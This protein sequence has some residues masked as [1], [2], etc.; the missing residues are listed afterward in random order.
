V[1]VLVVRGGRVLYNRTHENVEISQ[2]RTVTPVY[3][4]GP[5]HWGQAV[6]MHVEPGSERTV[7][8]LR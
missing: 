8:T 1:T 7:I 4:R 3:G 5:L 2:T 6:D